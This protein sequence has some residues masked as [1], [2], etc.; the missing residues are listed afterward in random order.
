[1]A[2]HSTSCRFVEF[3]LDSELERLRSG[4]PFFSDTDEDGG[5]TLR[6]GLAGIEECSTD[7]SSLQ[8]PMPTKTLPAGM[9]V[10]A[11]K[12]GAGVSHTGGGAPAS[13][14]TS[15]VRPTVATAGG[16]KLLAGAAN[17]TTSSSASKNVTDGAGHSTL[18]APAPETASIGSVSADTSTAAVAAYP[19]FQ[20]LYSYF[21][22][23]SNQTPR[24]HNPYFIAR[25]DES[26]V[27]I[28]TK[29]IA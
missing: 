12:P 9:R 7:T 1:M 18:Q 28:D 27:C 8:I 24:F 15:R 10:T 19:N 2:H 6:P 13:P 14:P 21:K 23:Y 11:F 26:K 5:C 20:S 3:M 25:K 29:C 22:Y 4:A 17:Q 16:P